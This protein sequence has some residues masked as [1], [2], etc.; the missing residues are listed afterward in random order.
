MVKQW[1]SVLDSHL[2]KQKSLFQAKC[3]TFF[4]LFFTFFSLIG[5]DIIAQGLE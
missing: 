2:Y 3:P 5:I 4:S 1:M